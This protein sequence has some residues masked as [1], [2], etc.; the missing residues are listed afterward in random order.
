MEKFT[1]YNQRLTEEFNKSK[2]SGFTQ[3]IE[4]A[5]CSNLVD[6][7][8]RASAS[9][10]TLR[11]AGSFF[12][13]DELADE[14]VSKLENININSRIMDPTCGAGNLLLAC[15]KKL[16]VNETLSETLKEW[17]KILYGY[18]LVEE[19][20]EA[21]KIRIVL[22]CIRRKVLVDIDNINDAKNFL[23]RMS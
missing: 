7:H 18:D 11:Q 12:T 2:L 21:T 14:L 6:Q 20:V 16:P 1:E 15:T 10:E 9:I 13:G 5:L 3:D 22:E 19:F 23:F 4:K 8:L 17:G